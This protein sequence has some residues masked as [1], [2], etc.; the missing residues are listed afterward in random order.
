[1]QQSKNQVSREWAIST[2]TKLS[3]RP[4]TI[5]PHGHYREFY[6]NSINSI[7]CERTRANLDIPSECHLLLFLG[8]IDYYYS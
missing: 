8:Y 2:W 4:H 6:P 7:S 3:D 1:M 5:I